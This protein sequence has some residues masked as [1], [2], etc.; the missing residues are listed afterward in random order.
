MGAVARARAEHDARSVST[1]TRRIK[2][3]APWIDERDEELV[4]EVLRSGQLSLS[5]VGPRFEGCWRR[6]PALLT[7][8]PCRRARPAFISA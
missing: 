4:L 7:A 1:A 5:P 8:L 6:W 2:L 3:S